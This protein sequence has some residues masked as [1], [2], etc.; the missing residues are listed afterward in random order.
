M[1]CLYNRRKIVL[2]LPLQKKIS[3]FFFTFSVFSYLTLLS[4]E[5]R[6]LGAALVISKFT[7]LFSHICS[8]LKQIVTRIYI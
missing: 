7:R 2:V 4:N 3:Y 8:G 6:K 5:T 1:R